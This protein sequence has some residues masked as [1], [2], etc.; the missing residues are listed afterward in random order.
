MEVIDNSLDSIGKKCP[1][2]KEGNILIN[3]KVRMI[4][5]EPFLHVEVIDNGTGFPI[6]TLGII[7]KKPFTDKPGRPFTLGG[8]GVYLKNCLEELES[9]GGIPEVKNIGN[10]KLPGGASVSILVPIV[11]H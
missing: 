6:N 3:L 1:N 8:T 10:D 11:L 5:N 7:G 4:E 9:L 2:T